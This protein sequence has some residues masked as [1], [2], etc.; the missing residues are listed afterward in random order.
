MP[1]WAK[2]QRG[3]RYRDL[4]P[5]GGKGAKRAAADLANY[6]ANKHAAVYCR[7]SGDARRAQMYEDICERIFADLPDFAKW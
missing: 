2:H 4:F 5:A 7:T 1:F 6:A 3:R